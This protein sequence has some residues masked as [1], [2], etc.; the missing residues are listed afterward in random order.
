MYMGTLTLISK[1]LQRIMVDK[2]WKGHRKGRWRGWL[3]AHRD[4]AQGEPWLAAVS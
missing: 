1:E 2:A 3:T 4:A